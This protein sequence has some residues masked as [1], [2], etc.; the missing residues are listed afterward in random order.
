MEQ[1][2][3]RPSVFRIVQTDYTASLCAIFPLVIWVMYGLLVYFKVIPDLRGRDP[4]TS[5]DAPFF[6]GLAV[7]ATL[8][9]IPLLVWRIRT[10]QTVFAR[11]V[12]VRAQITNAFFYRD[13]G[14]VDYIYDYQGQTYQSGN[15]VT[16]TGHTKFLEPGH[17]VILVVAPENPKKA[18]IREF[19]V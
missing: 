10:I 7:V 5:A 14:R 19:Y 8:L 9:G 18:F 15:A 12:E 4:L 2:A 1:T 13:R 11:G 3:R 16:K 6:F 17:E